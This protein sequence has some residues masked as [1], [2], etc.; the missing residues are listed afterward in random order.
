M[1]QMNLNPRKL[2]LIGSKNSGSASTSL[3]MGIPLATKKSEDKGQNS[4]LENEMAAAILDWAGDK[5]GGNPESGNKKNSLRKER[6][7]KQN[8]L[9]KEKK[10]NS[11]RKESSDAKGTLRTLRNTIFKRELQI[12]VKESELW[13]GLDEFEKLLDQTMDMSNFIINHPNDH[14]LN[15]TLKIN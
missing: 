14:S 9:R 10:Q 13:S 7:E 12:K 11:L 3:S 5:E 8:S 1:S 6:K 2:S 15:V 4:K